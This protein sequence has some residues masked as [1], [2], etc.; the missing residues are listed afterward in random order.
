M[1]K[2]NLL[3]IERTLVDGQLWFGQK[4]FIEILMLPSRFIMA[5]LERMA[6]LCRN[7]NKMNQAFLRKEKLIQQINNLANEQVLAQ[8]EALLTRATDNTAFL[9]RYVKP[10]RKKTDIELM[11]R[12]QNYKGVNKMKLRQI[13]QSIN[14]P[15]ST[16]ELLLML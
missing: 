6:Y 3:Y 4:L 13:T 5:L 1:Y 8:I 10:T 14:I 7:A 15:Q 16:D 12:E 9:H 2:N 11:I